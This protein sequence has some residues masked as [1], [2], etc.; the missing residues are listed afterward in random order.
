MLFD[1]G[2]SECGAGTAEQ[3]SLLAAARTMYSDRIGPADH[4]VERQGVGWYVHG[5]L[6]NEMKD[7][8]IFNTIAEKSV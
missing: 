4:A 5:L 3:D 1:C 2:A 8:S 7:K 6:A